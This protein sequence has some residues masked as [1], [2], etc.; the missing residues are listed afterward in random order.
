MSSSGAVLEHCAVHRF[1][2][3][4][5][6]LKPLNTRLQTRLTSE[7]RQKRVK[8]AKTLIMW[9]I[10]DWKRVRFNGGSLYEL[11]HHANHQKDRA[12]AGNSTE[13]PI[14][15]NVTQPVKLTIWCMMSFL[16]LP[17]HPQS[18]PR[19]NFNVR[20]LHTSMKCP[21][22]R[23]CRRRRDRK[24]ID[25]KLRSNFCPTYL[26][27]F[28]NITLSRLMTPSRPARGTRLT[29]LAPG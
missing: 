9:S 29:F 6:R 26:G 7:R 11:S 15:E 24:R 19:P 12:S 28:S 25:H 5:L 22:G 18:A 16:G 17:E 2:W 4:Y 23:R 27:L 14:T 8:F 10:R 1:Q 3:Q 20:L 13:L 21:K